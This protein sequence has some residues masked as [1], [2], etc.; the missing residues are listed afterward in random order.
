MT[1]LSTLSTLTT[2]ALA[3]VL[4]IASSQAEAKIGGGFKSAGASYGGGRVIR[5]H[6]QNPRP[7]S[8]RRHSHHHG[9]RR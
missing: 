6:R 9:G 7:W 1:S 2:A 4:I 5:D 3:S 8:P